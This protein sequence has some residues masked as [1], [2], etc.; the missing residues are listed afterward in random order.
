MKVCSEWPWLA[1]VTIF[2]SFGP[3][4][5]TI[6]GTPQSGRFLPGGAPRDQ[7]D[8]ARSTKPEESGSRACQTG[9]MEANLVQIYPQVQPQ[10]M[11]NHETNHRR[12]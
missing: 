2:D 1:F 7:V 5:F 11:K 3:L 4:K 12:E 9:Q 8:I 6:L 10:D